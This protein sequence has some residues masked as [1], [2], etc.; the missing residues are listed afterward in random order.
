MK[1]HRKTEIPKR[2]AEP[3]EGI[4]KAKNIYQNESS[5][6]TDADVVT[7]IDFLKNRQ[8]TFH[9]ALPTKTR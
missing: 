7:V 3:G 5:G 8:N 2:F 9:T 1:S 6:Y 4:R